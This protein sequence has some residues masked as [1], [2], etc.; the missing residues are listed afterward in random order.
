MVLFQEK[1]RNFGEE[2]VARGS[3]KLLMQRFLKV[4]EKPH[5]QNDHQTLKRYRCERKSLSSAHQVVTVG[6]A[7]S[8]MFKGKE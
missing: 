6:A 7:T 4:I 1:C 2:K 3:L 5:K 8:D